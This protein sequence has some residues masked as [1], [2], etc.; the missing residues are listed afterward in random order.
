MASPLFH[1]CARISNFRQQVVGGDIARVGETSPSSDPDGVV[2][3]VKVCILINPIFDVVLSNPVLRC[4]VHV[5]YA[6]HPMRAE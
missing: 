4:A 6:L 5:C 1:L 3:L 2:D